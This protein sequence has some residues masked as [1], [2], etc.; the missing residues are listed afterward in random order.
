MLGIHLL[1][2]QVAVAIL[3]SQQHHE[4]FFYMKKPVQKSSLNAEW[5]YSIWEAWV[6]SRVIS[7]H[8]LHL[9]FKSSSLSGS[10]S[11]QQRCNMGL[12]PPPVYR[13]GHLLCPLSPEFMRGQTI[14]T[15][16]SH[17]AAAS[18]FLPTLKA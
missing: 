4:Q 6:T 14:R 16:T 8:L 15:R 12:E 5:T 17:N 18:P 2:A 9:R 10:P 13:I 7:K 11:H 1:N 3:T